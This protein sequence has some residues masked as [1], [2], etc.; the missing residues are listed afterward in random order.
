MPE[1][2]PKEKEILELISNFCK[3][4][5]AV[6]ETCAEDECQL[7]LIKNIIEKESS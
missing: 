4:S 2:T 7:W 5:C 6:S 1:N 3:G